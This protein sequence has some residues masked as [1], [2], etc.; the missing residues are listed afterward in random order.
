MWK[1]CT[2]TDGLADDENVDTREACREEPEWSITKDRSRR[3]RRQP[4]RLADSAK[5][6][7]NRGGFNRTEPITTTTVGVVMGGE[8]RSSSTRP[9]DTP[10]MALEHVLASIARLETRI[11]AS[12]RRG[13]ATNQPP[14]PDPD[15][16]YAEWQRDKVESGHHRPVWSTVT[17][18]A[19]QQPL[20]WNE[21]PATRGPHFAF[22]AAWDRPGIAGDVHRGKPRS[23]WDNPS[24]RSDYRVERQPPGGDTLWERQLRGEATG[25][26]GLSP[27]RRGSF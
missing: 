1:F 11:D 21:G 27:S 25:A 22:Q 12:E 15:P 16:P 8:S 5:P 17:A 2:F 9:L 23:A 7:A 6:M 13:G 26:A 20:G 3:Q 4:R 24:R 19:A 18:V 14:R 10:T